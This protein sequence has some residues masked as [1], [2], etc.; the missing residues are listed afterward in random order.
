MALGMAK[1]RQNEE[2][3]KVSEKNIALSAFFSEKSVYICTCFHKGNAFHGMPLP[4][5]QWVSGVAGKG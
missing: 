4:S 2:K 5:G 3:F 1:R